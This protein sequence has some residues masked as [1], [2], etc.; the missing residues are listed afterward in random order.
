MFFIEVL[1]EAGFRLKTNL[2][3][4]ISLKNAFLYGLLLISFAHVAGNTRRNPSQ[5]KELYIA[6]TLLT[7]YAA[8]T[9]LF[10]PE[11]G[12]FRQYNSVGALIAVKNM[13]LDSL[14]ALL[15]FSV[16]LPRT[17]NYL[18][19]IRLMVLVLGAFSVLML[20]EVRFPGLGFYGFVTED[21]RPRGP[22]GEPNQTAAV[23]AFV[24]PVAIAMSIRAKGLMRIALITAAVVLVAALV[25]TG[26]RGGIVAAAGGLAFLL[27]AARKE[28][29]VPGRIALL[30]VLPLMV[31][32][33]W[34]LLPDHYQ[35]LIEQRLLSLGDVQA[36][37]RRASAGR[38][39]LWTAAL[40]AWKGS[41]V[42][43][44][45]WGYFGVASGSATHNEY[46]LYLVDTG[47][48]GFLLYMA[49]W[50]CALRLL[51]FARRTGRGDGLLLASFQAGVTSLMVAIF[52]VNLFLPWLVVWSLLGLMLAESARLIAPAA[53]Q[54]LM[55][56]ASPLPQ[57]VVKPSWRP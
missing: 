49:I 45:G 31:M 33:G 12:S 27:Y 1:L 16:A 20:L 42:L 5:L 55:G 44:H 47:V 53:N 6:F 18:R 10:S 36:D 50:I 34:A 2:V 17:T 26:S 35:L 43:G 24:L 54:R 57:I 13:L 25:V 39:M 4:G 9:V 51:H 23:L 41:P 8:V 21:R 28:M 3:Q 48:V 14:I 29:R 7:L 52:F 37:A 15:V 22:L 19:V 11:M 32:L 30:S 38:T 40:E 56:R 46:L